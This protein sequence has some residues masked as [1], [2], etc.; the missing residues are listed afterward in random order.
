MKRISL[1]AV[2]GIV[3]LHSAIICLSDCL[4]QQPGLAIRVAEQTSSDLKTEDKNGSS[5]TT[6]GGV[7]WPHE[8]SDL[9]PDPSVLWGRLANGFRYAIVPHRFSPN[10]VSLRLL[11]E[12]GSFME[13]DGQEG[14]AHFVEHM[15]FNGTKHQAGNAA[16]ESFQRQGLSFGAH[17]NAE[18]RCD[19]TVYKLE[20]PDADPVLVDQ[21]LVWCRD[22]MDGL[23]F[24]P[25]EVARERGV[26]LSEMDSGNTGAY[27]RAVNLAEFAFPDA[28]LSKRMP[29]GMRTTIE[30]V[31]SESLRKF[32]Q[33]FYRPDNA[34]LVLAGDID[35]RQIEELIEKHFETLRVNDAVASVPVIAVHQSVREQNRVAT[36]N[37]NDCQVFIDA[38][39]NQT[40]LSL[41]VAKELPERTDNWERQQNQLRLVLGTVMLSQ[42]MQSLVD[43]EDSPIISCSVQAVE[44][45]RFFDELTVSATI[46]P[47][48]AAAAID[49]LEQQMRIAV[50]HGFT[51][52]EFAAIIGYVQSAIGSSAESANTRENS[53]IADTLID[54]LC[55]NTV[56][57]H[58]TTD[59]EIWNELLSRLTK[60]DCRSA[61]EQFWNSNGKRISVSGPSLQAFGFDTAENGS[62]ELLAVF[63][64]SVQRSVLP[65]E[66][67]NSAEFGY[68]NLGQPGQVFERNHVQDLEV[69]Q[70]RFENNVRC[71]VK[72][73][74]L[75]KDVVHVIVRFGRGV[76]EAPK[77]KPGIA[78]LASMV[79]ISGGLG[80]HS[81]VELN[82]ILTEHQCSVV[83]QVTDDSFQFQGAA[84]KK[85]MQL[86]LQVIAAYTTDAAFR[87]L[88]LNRL[89]GNL[90]GIYAGLE[91]TAGGMVSYELLRY[92]RGGDERFG[93][94]SRHQLEAFTMNNV[95]EWLAEPLAR[96]YME[97]TIVGDV[98]VDSAIESVAAT[99]G[100]LPAREP[101]RSDVAEERSLE[102]PEPDQSRQWEFT[103]DSPAGASYLVWKT[104]VGDDIQIQRRTE[105]VGLLLQDRLRQRVRE[106]MGA[107]YS[108]KVVSYSG[109]NFPGYSYL[110]VVIESQATQI[111]DL[112]AI[113]TTIG[114][115]FGADSISDDEFKRAI[116]PYIAM[117]QENMASNQYWLQVLA[118]SQENPKTLEDVRTI[119]ADTR[120]I[121][122]EEV[123]QL[124]HQVFAERKPLV[125]SLI[126]QSS[127]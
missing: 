58:P 70:A 59:L 126:P 22:I 28:S 66:H 85:D 4:G 12:A 16:I 75:D 69:T 111:L 114:N 19:R 94:P 56:F 95:R 115:E 127:K 8:G 3:F 51:D 57:T 80:K 20:L 32:H 101:F 92:L 84:A 13:T 7:K 27:R 103:S 63:E 89:H 47:A 81:L 91:H 62:A 45:V 124:A 5:S 106:E 87:P 6:P 96:S 64:A 113:V 14:L 54:S 30:K 122:R 112:N 102:L 67:R 24:E 18:T 71:N 31:D 104:E 99:L 78:E 25:S 74:Q 40:L 97:V 52:D 86:L 90:D 109:E 116:T 49:A 33:T 117:L 121:T 42:R 88:S 29:I 100:T 43:Q 34:V 2:L 119:L 77:S 17:T 123:Q 68:G 73:T 11:I 48:K 10:R 15:A 98:D 44:T 60:E 46:R 93:F 41:I 108:P 26:V 36:N 53:Y 83:F 61:L 21:T 55:N 37:K 82:K 35:P 105:V 65:D 23:T 120:S 50:S 79:M 110:A 107:V 39:L 76:M 72:T 1:A 38:E 9:R 125:L 118:D